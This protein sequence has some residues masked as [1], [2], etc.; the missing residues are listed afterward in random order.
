MILPQAKQVEARKQYIK[1][2]DNQIA[3]VARVSAGDWRFW[4][5]GACTVGGD[6]AETDERSRRT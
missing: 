5:V 2:T 4:R 1:A 3:E 6:A